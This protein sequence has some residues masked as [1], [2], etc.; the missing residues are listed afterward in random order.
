[1]LL[2]NQPQLLV[3]DH[4]VDNRWGAE[5]LTETVLRVFHAPVKHPLNPLIGGRGG[6]VNVRR[7]DDG[8]FRMW[9]QEYWDQSLE[10]RRYTYAV[11]YAES[12][13]GVEWRLPRV[14]E[15]EFKGTRDNN[16]VLLG[17]RGGRA[18]TPFLLDI[19]ESER[20]GYRYVML[21]LTDD[22]KGAR[23]IGSH[24]GIRWDPR[25]DTAITDGFTPDTHA[26][27]V[28]DPCLERFVWFTRATDI[29]RARGA[30]RKVA[31]LEHRALWD[32]WPVRCENVLLPDEVD[33][34]AL[35]NYFYGMPT[36]YYAGMY[37]GLLW[38][39]RHQEGIHTSLAFSRDGRDFRRPAAR[40]ALV[41]VGEEGSWDGGMAMASRW[42]EVG[43][44]WWFYYCGTQ[45]AHKELDPQPGIGL[46][47]LRKEGFA[48]LRSPP[49]G[50]FVVTR[51]FGCPGGRLWLNADA[52]RGEIRIKATDYGRRPLEGCAEESLPVTGDAVRHEVRWP[53]GGGTSG[54]AGR[55]MRLEFET[56]G[57]VDLYAFGFAP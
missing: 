3:D 5:Y 15:H 34:G 49:G 11:A 7:G 48:S 1:M 2:D 54:L 29:Y 16:I 13:D 9:Y 17:P 28:W 18:E 44:E 14:G 20:R 35:N 57:E 23:L 26:S 25:S 40:P 4:L 51:V 37:W 36:T 21:Y 12:D 53:E 41:D 43:D 6:Y 33:A 47:R 52:G 45:G 27:I 39:Y 22:P 19:P 24:D 32:E 31:R 46:A 30:R 38:P 8:L 56:R 55:E 50:G 42:L 10:P